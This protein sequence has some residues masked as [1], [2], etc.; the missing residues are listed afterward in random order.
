MKSK[1]ENWKVSDNGIE[2]TI[3]IIAIIRLDTKQ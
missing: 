2:K 3:I 1:F